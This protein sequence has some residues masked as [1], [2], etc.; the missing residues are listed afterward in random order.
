ME[1][2]ITCTASQPTTETGEFIW[3]SLAHQA[4]S[5][6]TAPTCRKVYNTK[7]ETAWD[8]CCLACLVYFLR[9]RHASLSPTFSSLIFSHLG[10]VVCPAPNCPHLCSPAQVFNLSLSS[11]FNVAFIFFPGLSCYW[12]WSIGVWDS[13]VGFSRLICL[14]SSAE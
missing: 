4:T 9:S 5:C 3:P 13:W 7:R 14:T 8:R 6:K 11:S 10:V 2:L 1:L 12:S